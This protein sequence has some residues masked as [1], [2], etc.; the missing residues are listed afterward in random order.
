MGRPLVWHY[1]PVVD[2]WLATVMPLS[3]DGARSLVR[4]LEVTVH[5]VLLLYQ[6]YQSE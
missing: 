5:R 1:K 6:R 4:A 3:V 2:V